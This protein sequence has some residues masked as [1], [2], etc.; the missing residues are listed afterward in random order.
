M[1]KVYWS[2]YYNTMTT[3]WVHYTIQTH[4]KAKQL[5][6]KLFLTPILVEIQW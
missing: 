4:Y 5:G 2:E 3:F 1:F 6:L